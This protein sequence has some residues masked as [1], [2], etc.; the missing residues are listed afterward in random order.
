MEI[1]RTP[2]GFSTVGSVF[3]NV[4]ALVGGRI[5]PQSLVLLPVPGQRRSVS[6]TSHRISATR[7]TGWQLLVI[8]LILV[9]AMPAWAA[10]PRLPAGVPNIYDPEV[11]AHFLPVEVGNLGDNPDFP[12]VLLVNAAGE[13]P[14]GLIV[15]LDARNGT[16]AWS[17]TTDPVI[18][19]VIFA[20]GTTIQGSYVDTGFVDR[21]EASGNYAEVD[22]ESLS[23]LPDLFEAVTAG[24]TRTDV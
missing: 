24:A 10:Q 20:D 23:A 19:V 3:R 15:G 21:G 12:V 6:G 13:Q 7:L 8:G 16:D 11:R 5:F 9:A 1:Q 18:L 2:Q 4:T 14:Q 17:L 22:E